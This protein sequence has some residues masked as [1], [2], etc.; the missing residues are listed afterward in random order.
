MRTFGPIEFRS[1]RPRHAVAAIIGL[2]L[3]VG[4]LAT[5]A[6]GQIDPNSGIDFV[7]VGAPG[8]PAWTGDGTPGDGAIG[9]GSVSYEY[10][11][12]RFEV[13]TSQWV[14]FFN[15]AFD[16]PR[17]Q[18]LPHLVVPDFWGAVATT[19]T[20]QGGARWRVPP[21][22]EMRPVGDI[23]WR[24]AAMYCN[25]LCNDKST[26]RSAFLSG[27]YDV[28][29]FGSIGGVFT[30]QATRSPGARYFIP[31]WDEWLKAAHYDPNKPN[32]DGTVGGWWRYSISSDTAPVSGPPPS[33]AP[34]GVEAG[35][36][37]T[38]GWPYFDLNI[39]PSSIPLGAYSTAMSPWGLFDT[40]GGTAEWTEEI[41]QFFTAGN[42]FRVADGSWWYAGST[43]VDAIGLR[44][45]DD[46]PWIPSFEYGL[47]VAAAVPSP[48]A[49]LCLVILMAPSLSSTRR[50][51]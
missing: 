25:W 15:A 51:Y 17:D 28:S 34:A 23:S 18:W 19:S 16:R 37:N 39:N 41:R 4:A 48:S 46:F 3:N 11:I 30:D 1:Q 43:G 22:R 9:R 24:M 36:V 40:A 26:D 7:T 2:L 10:R 8:N 45:A 29:T 5:P 42:K 33:L 35:Q 21:G 31:T 44:A 38:G 20:T 12:G 6:V 49:A 50:R 32:A 13:T 27:A 14:E 47:R